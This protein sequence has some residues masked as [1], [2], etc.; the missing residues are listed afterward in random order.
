MQS[1]ALHH[2][3]PWVR[4]SCLGFLDHHAADTSTAVFIA[5]IAWIAGGG[6]RSLI[7]AI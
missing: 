4:R 5:A 7:A 2:G 3:D 6:D 1:A